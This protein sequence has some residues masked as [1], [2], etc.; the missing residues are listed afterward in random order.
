MSDGFIRSAAP[1][2]EHSPDTFS[3]EAL[4]RVVNDAVPERL[5]REES[6]TLISC[7]KVEGTVVF[8]C[9]GHRLGVIETLMIDKVSGTVRYAVLAFGGILGFGSRHCPLPWGQLHYD[10]GLGGYV[11]RLTEGEMRNAP[12][13][14]A[15]EA[16]DLACRE[17]GERVDGYYHGP[18]LGPSRL[19]L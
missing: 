10:T 19:G 15:E 6:L 1:P 11:V 13:Y 5:E 8:D 3:P 4:S 9:A 7:D 18:L 12:S 17:W 2:G 14:L 16:V